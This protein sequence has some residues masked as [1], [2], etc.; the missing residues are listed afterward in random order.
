MQQRQEFDIDGNGEVSPEEAKV[1]QKMDDMRYQSECSSASQNQ[2]AV[3]SYLSS[4]LVLPFGF[5]WQSCRLIVFLVRDQEMAST[6]T[7]YKAKM[8]SVTK[9]TNEPSN[10]SMIHH[11]HFFTFIQTIILFYNL[12]PS[13]F[14][15]GDSV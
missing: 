4:E 10:I 14:S 3:F 11:S 5:A 15:D 2:K 13:S 12:M 9:S 1:K 7:S 8:S 6:A